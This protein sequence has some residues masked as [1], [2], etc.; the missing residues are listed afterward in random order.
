MRY[1]KV[2][3]ILEDFSEVPC[4]T[5]TGIESAHD[6]PMQGVKNTPGLIGYRVQ[7][8]TYENRV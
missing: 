4:W 6:C 7:E 3:Y 2:W 5:Y 8:V 1:F